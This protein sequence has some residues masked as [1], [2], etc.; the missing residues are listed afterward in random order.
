MRLFQNADFR[1][2]ER[3]R[4]A[5]LIS[6]LAIAAVL[7]AMI[8]FEVGGGSWVNYGVDFTGGTLVQV[9]FQEPTTVG[10]LRST[11]SSF[12]A[13]VTRRYG[14]AGPCGP[15]SRVQS[16]RGPQPQALRDPGHRTLRI[17]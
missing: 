5:F 13:E 9:T 10:E 6:G 2:I 17:R 12:G 14:G 7:I 1:F 11:L 3:R 15:P 8:A 4:P 16:A